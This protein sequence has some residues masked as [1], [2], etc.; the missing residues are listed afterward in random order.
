IGQGFYRANSNAAWK[1]KNELPNQIKKLRAYSTTQGSIY[2]SSKN[3][4]TNPNGWT[5]TL[6]MHYYALP[7]LV[8]PM[9]WIDSVP[10]PKPTV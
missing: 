4:T 8:P 7:A 6:R 3:F 2:F 5:D 10:P 9:Y 1:D